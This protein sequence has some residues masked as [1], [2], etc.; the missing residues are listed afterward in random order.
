MCSSDGASLL[1][2][3][4]V[5]EDETIT[6]IIENSIGNVKESESF[7][8]GLLRAPSAATGVNRYRWADGSPLTYARWT[9]L[10]AFKGEALCGT[11]LFTR[12]NGS[13]SVRWN[14]NS[15]SSRHKF[16][17]K[18]PRRK[19]RSFLLVI[20]QRRIRVLAE[21]RDGEVRLVDDV[22]PT[23]GRLE[24]YIDGSWKGV[25]LRKDIYSS[26][27]TA[28]AA[29]RQMNYDGLLEASSRIGEGEVVSH[30][31]Y[32][33]E[34]DVSVRSCTTPLATCNEHLFVSCR[35][36]SVQSLAVRLVNSSAQL[37]NSSSERRM[38][39]GVGNLWKRACIDHDRHDQQSLNR[40]A[41]NICRHMG[42]G[43]GKWQSYGDRP[44]GIRLPLCRNIS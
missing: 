23:R 32:C 16:I 39:I 26:S 14:A 42:Y 25:C 29:C 33:T 6:A 27:Q 40:S 19:A 35:S 11:L 13:S 21:L 34:N 9:S 3:E 5:N 18:K 17:C 37:V 4:S 43:E 41:E 12:L 7:F 24:I 2:I 44:P 1:S 31:V 10:K 30:D 28:A 38:E 15:C 20:K 22:L 8:F 36:G